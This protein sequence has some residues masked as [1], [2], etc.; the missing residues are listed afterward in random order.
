[1]QSWCRRPR[2][3]ATAR[4]RRR[5]YRDRFGIGFFKTMSNERS[6]AY[7]VWGVIHSGGWGSAQASIM[8]LSPQTCSTT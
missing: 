7:V 2:S 6:G 8:A 3:V 5:Q 1:V 4:Q